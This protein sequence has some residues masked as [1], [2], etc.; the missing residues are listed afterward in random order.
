MTEVGAVSVIQTI[1]TLLAQPLMGRLAIAKGKKPLMVFYYVSLTT[2]PLGYC[3][4]QGFLHIAILSVFLGFVLA[5]GNATIL[6]YIL[7]IIP[8]DRV[9]ELTSIYNMIAGISYFTGSAIGGNVDELISLRF[10]RELSLK[11]GY[12]ISAAGRLASGLLFL[13]IGEESSTRRVGNAANQ[14]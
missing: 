6:P 9:G 5:M 2:V 1:A 13:K 8:E 10:G 7:D 4:A 14:S 11:T 12:F 3:F